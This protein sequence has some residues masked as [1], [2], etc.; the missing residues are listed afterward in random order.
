MDMGK[1]TLRSPK[2]KLVVLPLVLIPIAVFMAQT[3][4]SE[5][6]NELRHI[7]HRFWY[8]ILVT[9]IAYLFGTLSWYACLGQYKKN[10]SLF[11]LFA[12]R[13][14]GETVGLYN[15][16]SVVGGDLL[17]SEF[18]SYHHIPSSVTLSSV[19]TSR[20]TAVLSQLFLF[21]LAMMWLLSS[22]HSTYIVSVTG[23]SIY[24]FL[25]ILFLLKIAFIV[26]LFRSE[27]DTIKPSGKTSSSRLSKY[28]AAFRNKAKEIKRTIRADV[29]AFWQSYL[30]AA[31]HW[32]VGSV[33]FYLLLLFLG[34]DIH[35]MSGLLLD[36]SVIV[37]KSC[38]AFVPG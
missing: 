2:V 17:K 12:I 20:L 3:D 38:A 24:L 23:H 22:S 6:G 28:I 15:P 21:F 7:G 19:V 11:Q 30:Y 31:I 1:L 32:I 25:L 37:I 16:T 5:V 10:L 35:L 14:V 34:Y 36:M 18:L 4:F 13:Q 29:S 26:W 33:E 9:F 27:K 8:L